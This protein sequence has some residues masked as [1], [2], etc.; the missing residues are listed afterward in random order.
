MTILK[1]SK[2]ERG[3]CASILP[4]LLP[5]SELKR[6]DDREE[7]EMHTQRRGSVFFEFLHFL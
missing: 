6:Q 3:W 4:S 7:R 1:K 2:K 5:I